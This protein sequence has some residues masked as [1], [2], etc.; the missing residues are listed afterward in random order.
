MRYR[1]VDEIVSLDLGEPARI[2]VRK[3]FDS[4]DDALTGPEGPEQVPPSLVLELMA[5]TGGRLIFQRLGGHR[6]PLLLKVQ[7]C[8]FLAA[9]P[10]G[11]VLCAS[12]EL[13]AVSGDDVPVAELSAQVWAGSLRVALARFLYMCVPVPGVDLVAAAGLR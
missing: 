4:G 2:E 12:A 7:G 5:T 8:D 6:L 10:A 11:H 13:A 1:F 9:C 3:T